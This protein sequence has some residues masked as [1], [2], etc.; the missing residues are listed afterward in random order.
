MTV[1]LTLEFI[2]L[3]VGLIAGVMLTVY[4][5]VVAYHAL[6]SAIMVPTARRGLALATARPDRPWPSVCVI[7]PAHNEEASIA[8]AARSILGQDYPALRVVFALD[9]CTDRTS[10]VVRSAIGVD[11][12][13]ETLE[14]AEC[15]PDWA[16]KVH[17]LWTAARTAPAATHADLLLLADADTSFHPSCV[18]ACV[19]LMERRGL[20]MLS[21]LS[22]MTTDRWFEKAVQPAAG[23]ELIRQYPLTRANAPTHRRPFANGQFILVDR[24]AYERI[25][26]HASVRSALLEDVEFARRVSAHGVAAGMFLARGMLHCRMYSRW[27]DFKRGWTRIYTESAGRKV[28]RLRTQAG[29]V[30]LLGV[31][32]PGACALGGA[33]AGVR[34]GAS[35]IAPATLWACGAGFAAWISAVAVCYAMGSTPLA[36]V[37]LYPLGAWHVG[38]IQARAATDLRRGGKTVWGGREYPLAER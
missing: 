3:V 12:R 17:A 13:A 11:T 6:R 8:E 30:R 23:M 37:L 32:L 25:G 14:I 31:Y 24:G 35:P 38:G 34:L 20:G 33:L 36:Y 19:A 15:P 21:L 16:G 28:R 26:G 4:W 22:T 29:R 10:E 1:I 2:V 7:V 5:S 27:D 9:R 18:R